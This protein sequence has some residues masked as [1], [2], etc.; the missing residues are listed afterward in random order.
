MKI[1]YGFISNSSS[2]SFM[3]VGTTV[4]TYEEAEAWEDLHEKGRSNKDEY[5]N[6]WIIGFSID[7]NLESFSLDPN[8]FIKKIQ[9]AVQQAKDAGIEDPVIYGGC[10]YDG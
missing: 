7:P 4:Y 2:S 1:R 5:E 10:S 9:E 6:E 8:L 3:L